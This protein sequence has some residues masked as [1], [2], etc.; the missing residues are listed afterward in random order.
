MIYK[1]HGHDFVITIAIAFDIETAELLY[2]YN[3]V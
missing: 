2:K 3:T 1:L